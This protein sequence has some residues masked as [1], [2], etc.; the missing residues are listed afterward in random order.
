MK[1][2]AF[3]TLDEKPKDLK[4]CVIDGVPY[5]VPNYVMEFLSR[6]T[7]GEKVEFSFTEGE[8]GRRLTKIMRANRT[9][10]PTQVKEPAKVPPPQLH[11]VRVIKVNEIALKYFN[12]SKDPKIAGER[13][14][15]MTP[16]QFGTFTDAGIKDGDEI[17]I[18]IDAQGYVSLPPKGSTPTKD[19]ALQENL[20]RMNGPAD[21]EIVDPPGGELIKAPGTSP[22]KATEAIQGKPIADPIEKDKDRA[23]R[24]DLTLGGTINLQNYENLKVELTGPACDR[25][26]MIACV[27]ETLDLFGTGNHA[28]R[29]MIESYKRRVL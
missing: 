17:D 29:E 16:A 23:Y 28:T 6:R 13:V 9:E 26:Q 19:A 21:G 20:D 18:L 15:V 22:E 12:L 8:A 3:G 4:S 10:K 7:E 27:K 11:H 2:T 25:E 24:W 5:T 1:E 14:L